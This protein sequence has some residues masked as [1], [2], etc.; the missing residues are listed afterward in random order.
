M[1][2]PPEPLALEKVAR[3]LEELLETPAKATRPAGP[4]VGRQPD[5]VIRVGD[6]AYLVEWKVS[7]DVAGVSAGIRQLAAFRDGSGIEHV[8]LLAVPFM[9]DAGRRICSESGVSWLDLSGNAHIDAP[10]VHVRV[11]GKENRF[12]RRGRPSNPFAPKSSRVARWLLLHQGEFHVQK[13]IAA[14]IDVGA[15]FVSRVVR[16]LEELELIERNERGGVRVRD[17]ELLLEAWAERY[18][19]ERHHLLR[20]HVAARSGDELLARVSNALSG[21]GI[22]HAATGLAGAWLLTHFAAFRTVTCFVADLPSSDVLDSLGFHEEERGANLWL[23]LP[24][25]EGVFAGVEKM[26]GLPCASPIQVW[27]DLLGQPERAG[28]AARHIEETLLSWSSRA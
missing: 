8:A 16:R 7:G 12:K 28:E 2:P 21:A 20:G 5:A 24:V 25:D 14:A 6:H 27:L 3:R 26:D 10:G 1:K 23:A 22:E 15:G 11:E 13:E 9:G 18:A 19:F 4:A 17:P